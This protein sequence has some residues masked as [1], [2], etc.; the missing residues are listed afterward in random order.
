M[1]TV[2]FFWTRLCIVVGKNPTSL[3]QIREYLAWSQD[4]PIDIYII[5]RHSALAEEGPAQKAQVED[6]VKTVMELLGPHMKRWSLLYMKLKHSSSLPRPRIDLTGHASQLITL[7]LECAVDDISILPDPEEGS[8]TLG[9]FH[10]PALARLS[11]CGL[12]FRDAYLQPF[13][14]VPM[15]EAL[16]DITISHYGAHRAPL[17]LVDLLRCLVSCRRLS[18]VGLASLTLDCSYTG[19]PVIPSPGVR[20]SDVAWDYL[21]FT[22]MP[23]E[24][25]GECNRLLARPY[26]ET[27]SYSRCTLGTP[28]SGFFQ[29][30][31]LRADEIDSP[32]TLFALL[33][34]I[35]GPYSCSEATF[36][37]CAGLKPALWKML[38]L[39]PDLTW[40]CS[41]LKSLKIEGCHEI[42]SSDLRMALQARR[43]KH[44]ETGFVEEG[45]PAFVVTSI[46]EL[47][48]EDCCE[49][50]QEDKEWLDA[51]VGWVSWDDW[52]GGFARGK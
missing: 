1:S 49:L 37:H 12:H 40:F 42:T 19:P 48:V 9:E 7:E 50:A 3:K 18:H 34:A 20:V 46:C 4:R 11:M 14:Q 29:S 45:H 36:T 43:E 21:H 13:P 28:R 35:R 15:P 47:E 17:A 52:E 39:Y 23:C 5:E 31:Y 26:V 44:A 10:T 22:D 32:T 25:I 33:A 41:H 24:V 6:Q 16:N 27:V 38:M 30:F 8:H 51:N 2:A